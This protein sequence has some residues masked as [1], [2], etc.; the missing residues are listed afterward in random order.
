MPGYGA[1]PDMTANEIH[2]GFPQGARTERSNYPDI[3]TWLAHR[4]PGSGSPEA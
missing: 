2:R 3:Q 4:T 1:P